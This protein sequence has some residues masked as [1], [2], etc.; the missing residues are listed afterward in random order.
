MSDEPIAAVELV[1]AD[2][3][4]EHELALALARNALGLQLPVAELLQE[5]N[6]DPYYV[7]QLAKNKPFTDMVKQY[8]AEL[9]KDGMGIKL[10]SAVALEQSIPRLYCLVHN[11]NTPANVV[12]QGVKQLADMAGVSKPDAEATAAN[13]AGFVVNIDLSGLAELASAMKLTST[14][15]PVIIDAPTG[16]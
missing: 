5:L 1:A 15:A 8:R 9:E 12:V 4:E 3:M 7:I 14:P 6:I 2:F 10:K 16:E 11:K 13:G